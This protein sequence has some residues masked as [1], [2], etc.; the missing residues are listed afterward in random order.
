MTSCE[1]YFKK[2]KKYIDKMF[3]EKVGKSLKREIF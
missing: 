1:S 3:E 2:I